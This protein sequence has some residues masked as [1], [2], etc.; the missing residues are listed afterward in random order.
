MYLSPLYMGNDDL[1]HPDD[2]HDRYPKSGTFFPEL[3]PNSALDYAH[4]Q[5]KVNIFLNTR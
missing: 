5:E 4:Q 1:M 2:G 3:N